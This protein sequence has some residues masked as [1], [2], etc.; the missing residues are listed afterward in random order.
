MNYTVE[1]MSADSL[2]L[3]SWRFWIN[4]IEDIRLDAYVKQTRPS[5]RHKW[6]HKVLICWSRL[7]SRISTVNRKDFAVPTWVYD[8]LRQLL[9]QRVTDT[10]VKLSLEMVV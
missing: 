8:D 4:S 2:I 9:C 3:E 7:D 1:K 5:T 10:L 6:A